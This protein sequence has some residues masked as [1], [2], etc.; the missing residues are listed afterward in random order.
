MKPIEAFPLMVGIV[1]FSST[2]PAADWPQWRGPGRNGV[3]SESGLLKE[4][5]EAGPRLLWRVTELGA[6]YSTPAVVGERLYVLSNEGMQD[7]FVQA[8]SVKDG[9]RLWRMRLGKVGN[10]EQRPNFPAARST[11]T[12]DGERLYALGS[13]GDLACVDAGTGRVRWR[14]SL[15]GDF[16]G[17]PGTWAYAESLL[18][19]GDTLLC[20]PGG[21]E[22]TVVALN[23]K[24]GAVIWKS[25]VPGGDAAAYTSAIVVDTL[26]PKQYVQMLHKGLVGLEAKT[27]KVLWRYSK[28]VSQYGANIPTPL[29]HD[30]FIYSAGAGTGGA[31]VKLEAA[32]EGVRVEEVY[33]SAQLPT[34]IGG[35]VLVSDHLYGTSNTAMVCVEFASGAVKWR[36][37]AIGAASICFADG[38][39]Y[40]HGENGNVALVEPSP[41][42]YREKGRF[43]PS[44]QPKRKSRM[45]KAWT[46]P[47]VAN[48][49]LYLRD[50]NMLWCY[51]VKASSPKSRH[52]ES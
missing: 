52:G 33:S 14:K 22:A 2:L 42:G 30:Q 45:E 44:D 20:T 9:R 31:L 24:S 10:P 15:R 34:A 23:K 48:G 28:T 4:W 19:D 5:P 36:H 18:L 37:R 13:D 51:D 27:G 3:S 7:E 50:H 12:V 17:K 43:S 41:E 25:A 26:G 35:C 32:G 47:V 1:L 11:P 49:R 39:L 29:A 8:H 16:G 21:A 6:G 38:R 40:L 46:Y